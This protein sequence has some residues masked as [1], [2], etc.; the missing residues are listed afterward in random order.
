[1][2]IGHDILPNVFINNIEIYQN[3][4]RYDIVILDDIEN[5]AWSNKKSLDHKLKIKHGIFTDES[6]IENI[7]SG[8]SNFNAHQGQIK[9][10][11]VSKMK[12]VTTTGISNLD[13]RIIY[14]KTCTYAFNEQPENITIFANVFIDDANMQGPVASETIFTKGRLKTITN[15]LYKSKEQ[16]YGPV[17]YHEGGY[18]EGKIHKTTPHSKI[19]VNSGLNLKIKDLRGKIYTKKKLSRNS[20]TPIFGNLLASFNSETEFNYMFFINIEQLIISKTKFGHLYK[21]LQLNERETI[22]NNTVFSSIRVKRHSIEN[23]STASFEIKDILSGFE[24]STDGFQSTFGQELEFISHKMGPSIRAIKFHDKTIN[25]NSYGRYRYELE[26]YFSD[27]T[28]LYFKT[29]LARLSDAINKLEDFSQMLSLPRKYDKN[30]RKIKD[31]TKAG[32]F[33]NNQ[34]AQNFCYLYSKIKSFIYMIPEFEKSNLLMNNFNLISPNSCTIESVA[35]FTSNM[36]K[37]YNELVKIY[38]FETSKVGSNYTNLVGT[39]S[40]NMTN[41]IFMKH[42]F[43]KIIK[44]SDSKLHYVFEKEEVT[45]TNLKMVPRNPIKFGRLG[46]RFN[47]EKGQ[48]NPMI[49]RVI[50]NKFNKRNR[51][52]TIVPLSIKIEQPEPEKFIEV[53]ELLGSETNLNSFTDEEKCENPKSKPIVAE[54]IE[55]KIISESQDVKDE[56]KNFTTKLEILSG[57]N[58]NKEGMLAVTQPIWSPYGGEI[59]SDSTIVKQIPVG[60]LTTNINYPYPNKYKLINNSD[61]YKFT[62]LSLQTEDKSLVEASQLYAVADPMFAQ[63]NIVLSHDTTMGVVSAQATQSAAQATP[64]AAQ[65]TPST[66]QPSPAMASTQTNIGGY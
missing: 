40:N 55:L 66:P 24:L 43:K 21:R 31:E 42:K 50:K 2:I 63:G 12:K 38:G 13:N 62:D 25:Q 54:E 47:F 33:S 35:I 61:A 36:K 46:N 22:L 15:I 8:A 1:M 27:Q 19:E 23:N 26:I 10:E 41:K 11:L 6:E 20:M 53:T 44:P 52:I 45:G 28:V 7:K 39:K 58:L 34:L 16:Y 65:A 56:M 51:S 32:F 37:L 18:M 30:T 5:P 64:S 9:M 14:M 4:L 17:H 3:S 29:L 49:N 48:T 59:M 57:F 60:D